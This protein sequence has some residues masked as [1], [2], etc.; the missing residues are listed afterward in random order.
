MAGWIIILISLG[1]LGLLFVLAHFMD[2]RARVGKHLIKYK[3]VYALGI[4][5]YCTAWTYYGS[6]GNA[7]NDGW[8]F[9]T[10]Y[11]G[12]LLTM[13]LW[14][15]VMRKMIRICEVQRISTLPDLISLRYGKSL[16]ISVLSS[17]LIVLGIIPYISIQLKSITNSYEILAYG[18]YQDSNM[19]NLFL[20]D[21]AFYL[22]VILALFIILFVFRSIET[23]DKHFGMMG[24]IAIDSVVKLVAFIAVGVYVT[25]VLFNGFGDIF[26]QIDKETLGKFE[27]LPESSGIEWF[28]MLLLS[29]SAIMLLPRQFQ[30]TVAENTNENHLKTAIWVFPLY[31]LL[32]NIF[33]VPIAMGGKLLLPASIDPDSYVLAIP[34]MSNKE[35]LALF[36]F[37]GG[38]SAATG[39]IIVSTISLALILSNNVI[40]PVILKSLEGRNIYSS[41]PLRSRRLA[42]FGILILAYL[43][44][45]FIADRFPL[46]SIGLIS[47]A[48]IIQFA[49]AV[50]GALFWKDANKQGAMSGLIIGFVVWGYTL[51]I[52]TVIEVGL[53]PESLMHDGPFGIGWLRPESLFGSSLPFIAHGT[54][55]SLFFNTL[56]FFAASIF[57]EQSGKERNQAELYVDIYQYS[58]KSA[59]KLVWKGEMVYQDLVKLAENLLGKDRMA[60]AIDN[61][62]QRYGET[63]QD[64][65][66]DAKFV[67]Y[68][69]R[70]LSGAVGS[71]SAHLLISSMAKEDEIELKD[72]IVL[73]KET[74]ETAR[75]NEE[76]QYKSSQLRRQADEL[77]EANERL[78]NLDKEKD[79]FISTVTHEMRTPLTAIKAFVEIIQDNPEIEEQ[80]R[81]RF[82]GTI[83]DEIDRMTRLINQVLDMEK[84]ESGATT[85]ASTTISPYQILNDSIKSLEHLILSKEIKLNQQ[86]GDDVNSVEITGDEDRLKQ[87]FIN[88]ISNAIKYASEEQPFITIQCET[89]QSALIISITDNGRGIKKENMTRIFEKFF[90]ARDQTRKKPKGTGLGLSISKKIIELHK[91]TIEVTSE[92]QKG[93][94]FIIRL[95]TSSYIQAIEEEYEQN[96]NSR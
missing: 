4:P 69:E 89:D 32:I 38:F 45:K 22:S 27:H 92:W 66:V 46:A 20:N 81:S 68:T 12:P 33:V 10:I 51:V 58:T 83:N 16:T 90:Q 94:T 53:L 8:E 41:L 7:V 19:A 63:H 77:E 35:G 26:S 56:A 42:V 48:A 47:F 43:Y 75:L 85:I 49:P 61:Y 15:I 54:L 73:L 87:V 70:L 91:G 62:R 11:I 67:N 6:V 31:L 93:S 24:A 74:S 14:W 50:L 71:A 9:L 13:P 2:K 30:V 37:I 84:L 28:F 76:L 3:W 55:W 80:E 59:E 44:Y 21:T 72:V 52:P 36:T 1:Y 96:F 5:V 78:K 65:V 88:L 86:F 60:E 64:G 29:M 79:D 95:P 25:Y 57:T 82:L 18:A 39:M 40:V 34:L 17:V 23:T